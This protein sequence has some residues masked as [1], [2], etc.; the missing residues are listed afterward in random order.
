MRSFVQVVLRGALCAAAV[1]CAGHSRA[2]EAP[3]PDDAPETFAASPVTL[4]VENRNWQDIVVYGVMDG[5]R[6][7]LGMVVS[8]TSKTFTLRGGH[9][10]RGGELYFIADPIGDSHNFTSERVQVQPG[11]HI[12]WTLESGLERS[13]LSVR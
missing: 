10:S 7:R 2:P 1:A 3:D 11:A 4:T 13:S 5:T 8:A 9:M 12:E 6:D